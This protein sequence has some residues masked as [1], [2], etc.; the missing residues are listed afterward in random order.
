LA[1]AILSNPRALILDEPTSA[2][3]AQAT[4]IV[5]ET[6]KRLA[7]DKTLIVITHHPDLLGEGVNVINLR[8]SSSHLRAPGLFTA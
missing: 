8:S 4:G 2:L 1:R 6:L 3:D 7:R 5:V